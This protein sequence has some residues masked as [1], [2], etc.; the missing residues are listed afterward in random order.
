MNL[1]SRR[2]RAQSRRE[3]KSRPTEAAPDRH[4]IPRG[5]SDAGPEGQ[6]GVAGHLVSKGVLQFDRG[7]QCRSRVIE[8]AQCLISAE[9]HQPSGPSLHGFADDRRE[10]R[11]QT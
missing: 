8:D 7:P 3:V 5:Q 11:R 2:Q 4:G 10:A 6:R 1:A 9:L